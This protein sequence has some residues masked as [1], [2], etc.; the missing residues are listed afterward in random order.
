MNWN[1]SHYFPKVMVVRQ[2]MEQMHLADPFCPHILHP[3][4]CTT[5]HQV[6]GCGPTE[7]RSTQKQELPIDPTWTPLFRIPLWWPKLWLQS[8]P[9]SSDIMHPRATVRLVYSW[10][11][12]SPSRVGITSIRK[13]SLCITHSCSVVLAETWLIQFSRHRPYVKPHSF[14]AQHYWPGASEKQPCLL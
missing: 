13:S 8:V 3:L 9:E 7:M 4:S 10:F 14:G 2:W 11:S 12:N 5:S 6:P 1:R